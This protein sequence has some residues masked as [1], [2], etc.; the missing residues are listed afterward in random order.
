MSVK[1]KVLPMLV[2]TATMGLS[3]CVVHEPYGYGSHGGYR[4]GYS[5][6]YS[7]DYPRRTIVH[8]DRYRDDDRYRWRSGH[9]NRWDDN[10]RDNDGIHDRWDR[11]D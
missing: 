7:S 8:H 2:L 11:H 9:R 10:D 5:R 1:S 4:H 3:A 6:V